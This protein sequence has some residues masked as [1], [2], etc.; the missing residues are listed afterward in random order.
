VATSD[1]LFALHS[2]L[3]VLLAPPINTFPQLEHFLGFGFRPRF[4]LGPRKA[5]AHLTEQKAGF[6]PLLTGNKQWQ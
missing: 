5:D 6:L 3:H 1:I 2:M 4:F